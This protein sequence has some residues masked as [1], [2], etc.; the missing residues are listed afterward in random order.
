M[1]IKLCHNLKE[2]QHEK[3]AKEIWLSD[4]SLWF[5]LWVFMPVHVL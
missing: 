1:K 5:L 2:M 4:L 3:E